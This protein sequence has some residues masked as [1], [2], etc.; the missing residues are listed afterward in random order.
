MYP[1]IPGAVQIGHDLFL[2]CP[3]E[4]DLLPAV[5]A[6]GEPHPGVHRLPGGVYAHLL[7][8]GMGG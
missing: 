7:G 3:I 1:E 8:D 4:T 5:S 6:G 2:G